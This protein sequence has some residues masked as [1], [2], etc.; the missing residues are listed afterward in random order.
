MPGEG[1]LQATI[2]A[3]VRTG[4]ASAASRGLRGMDARECA[5]DFAEHCLRCRENS[6][7]GSAP[8]CGAALVNVCARRFAAGRARQARRR[9]RREA[10][11]EEPRGGAGGGQAGAGNPESEALRHAFWGLVAGYLQ[12]LPEPGRSYFVRHAVQGETVQEIARSGCRSEASVR[13]V[14]IRA[15]R[16]LAAE[17][18]RGAH[19]EAELRGWLSHLA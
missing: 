6:R 8:P 2:A 14:L 19:D 16:R 15:A 12:R 5:V 7:N 17:L 3:R 9:A 18:S 4:L 11:L 1:N 10:P 13:M